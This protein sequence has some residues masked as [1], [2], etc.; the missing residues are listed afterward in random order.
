LNVYEKKGLFGFIR[1]VRPDYY[2]SET[3]MPA[4]I[5]RTFIIRREHLA[6]ASTFLERLPRNMEYVFVHVRRG[7]Y[8]NSSCNGVMNI[9]LPPVYYT[10]AMALVRQSLA[11]PYFIVV[12]DDVAYCDKLFAGHADLCVSR[13]SMYVDFA[14]MTLCRAAIISNS[15]FSWWGA[16]LGV[17]K[18]AVISPKYWYGWKTQ[19]EEP[20]FIQASCFI[21]IDFTWK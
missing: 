5:A 10:K 13:N 9:S 11:S 7:D 15:T 3:L 14:I 4:D 1:H 19:C 16:M 18:T 8:L 12:T 21:P 20:S 2:T 17:V 6:A